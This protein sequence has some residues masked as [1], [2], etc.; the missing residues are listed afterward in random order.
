MTTNTLGAVLLTVN[1]VSLFH[2]IRTGKTLLAV[3]STVGVFMSF[4]MVTAP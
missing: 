1:A 2:N 3:M 4:Y